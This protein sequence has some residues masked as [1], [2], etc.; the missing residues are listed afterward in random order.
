MGIHKKISLQSSELWVGQ[1]SN[2][3]FDQ[4][5]CVLLIKEKRGLLF[6]PRL[7]DH[8]I[9][10]ILHIPHATLCGEHFDKKYF[11]IS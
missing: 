11:W 3:K 5:I 8:S 4:N 1:G 6:F 7:F 9:K 10:F 2:P